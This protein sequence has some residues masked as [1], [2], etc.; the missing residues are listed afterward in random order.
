MIGAIVGDIA[1]LWF[2]WCNIKCKEFAL[3][4]GGDEALPPSEFTDDTVKTLAVAN[5][6]MKCGEAG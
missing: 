2:E 4:A 1:G 6:I 5:A 3:F